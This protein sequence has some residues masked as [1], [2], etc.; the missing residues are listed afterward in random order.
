MPA[1][2][3]S[4][5]A[6]SGTPLPIVTKLNQPTLAG[7]GASIDQSHKVYVTDIPKVDIKVDT[8]TMMKNLQNTLDQLNN[9]LKDGGRGVSFSIDKS[10]PAPVVVV[11]NSTTGE[12]IRQFPNE[13]VVSF[14]DNLQGLKGLLANS[15]V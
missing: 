5:I 11:K 6:T 9:E 7:V 15:I 8:E 13:A 2:T 3:Q 12:V 4:I 14:A 10:L 1:E